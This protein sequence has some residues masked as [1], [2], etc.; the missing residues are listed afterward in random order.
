MI[1][2]EGT[3]TGVVRRP[4]GYNKRLRAE[5]ELGGYAE[6]LERAR[7]SGRGWQTGQ[8]AVLG[9]IS[10][11]GT[12]KSQQSL[13]TL[14]APARWATGVAMVL[15]LVAAV[16]G[17]V[18]LGVAGRPLPRLNR[19]TGAPDAATLVGAIRRT[20]WQI[21]AGLVSTVTAVCL[22]AVAVVITW[23]PGTSAQEGGLVRLVTTANTL[24]GKLADG[25]GSTVVVRVGKQSVSTPSR[26]VVSL[27]P[28]TSC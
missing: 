22:L 14:A 21:R 9:L 17:V 8:V 4:P 24:C 16:A 11:V 6:Q 27:A 5:R 23:V 10:V 26:D 18:L 28:V 19:R 25:N 13:E 12:V 1:R 15:A 2:K 20:A 3:V 7:E